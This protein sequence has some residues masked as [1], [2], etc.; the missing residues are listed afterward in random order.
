MIQEM[1]LESR[2]MKRGLLGTMYYGHWNMPRVGEGGI[3]YQVCAIKEVLYKTRIQRQNTKKV[4]TIISEIKQ[5]FTL[6]HKNLVRMYDAIS[7]EGY[8]YL[9]WQFIDGKDLS[10]ILYADNEVRPNKTERYKWSYEVTLALAYMH[11]NNF[12]HRDIKSSNVMIKMD[13]SGVRIAI[14][15]PCQHMIV[16]ELRS[17][18]LLSV[19]R[20]PIYMAPEI[21]SPGEGNVDPDTGEIEPLYSECSRE[22]KSADVY[23]LAIII[24]EILSQM[25]PFAE[26]NGNQCRWRKRDIFIVVTDITTHHRRPV[27]ANVFDISI[28]YDVI[29][30]ICA[31]WNGFARHRPTARYIADALKIALTSHEFANLCFE[32]QNC[33]DM[34]DG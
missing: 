32:D 28:P 5:Y 19:C 6:Q 21:I 20:T 27:I 33:I 25:R 26:V 13:Q 16:R 29:E 3:M 7:H 14:L 30:I 22:A 9:C 34:D 2:E 17:S 24:N 18:D 8:L 11:D 31:A 15:K 12:L 10:D 4:A 1:G 23:S